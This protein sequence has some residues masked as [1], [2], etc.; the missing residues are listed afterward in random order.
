MNRADAA[1]AAAAARE[2]SRATA[3]RIEQLL[4]EQLQP[5]QLELHDDS[6]AHAGHRSSGGRGHFRL[7]IVSTR[8]AGLTPL[9]RHRLVNEILAPLW[10]RELHAISVVAATPDELAK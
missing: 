9:Q 2:R 4:R 7:R 10:D 3:E 8:F 6:A 5:V 1:A